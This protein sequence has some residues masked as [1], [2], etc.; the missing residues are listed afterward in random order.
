MADEHM[1]E[2]ELYQFVTGEYLGLLYDTNATVR[3]LFDALLE[4]KKDL[5]QKD[6]VIRMLE[7]DKY[8]YMQTAGI[9]ISRHEFRTFF[10]TLAERNETDA[11][12][13]LFI[14]TFEYDPLPQSKK[15]FSWIEE[16]INKH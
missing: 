3:R 6:A 15:V 1:S 9:G 13:N 7:R 5:H 11:E 12:W 14:Q 8:L 10:Q 4:A 2:N 16:Y